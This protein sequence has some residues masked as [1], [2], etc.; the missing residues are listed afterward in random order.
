M[1]YLH[2][3]IATPNDLN[4]LQF[5]DKQEHVSTASGEDSWEWTLD[6][7]KAKPWRWVFIAEVNSKP[8]GVLQIIDPALEETHY[9]D[10]CELGLRAIDIWIGEVDFVNKGYGTEMM[11][12][13]I[14]FCF[15]SE[16]VKAILIDPLVSN[17]RAIR[18]YKR[19]GFKEVEKRRF[20]ND[21]CLVLRLN[22]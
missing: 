21:L 16:E 10:E 14:K 15:D 4:L 5:W 19:F 20:G 13:A 17:S 8:I 2:L 18:F 6:D 12:K 22:R 3:R 7:V 9:W 1:D 11:N